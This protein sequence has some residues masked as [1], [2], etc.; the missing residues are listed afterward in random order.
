MVRMCSS[1]HKH[2]TC[3]QISSIRENILKLIDL[4]IINTGEPGSESKY[5]FVEHGM[6]FFTIGLSI[7]FL[8]T[9]HAA[10]KPFFSEKGE[11]S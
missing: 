5:S 1:S 9:R 6:N 2:P 4:K 7:K 11:K 3:V 10:R 8:V